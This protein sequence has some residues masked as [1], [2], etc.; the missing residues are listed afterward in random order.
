MGTT[1]LIVGLGNPGSKYQKTRHNIGY[2]VVDRLAR[3]FKMKSSETEDDYEFAVT[4]YTDDTIVLMRPL[5]F[6][7]RS[8]FAVREFF[9][10]YEVS[11][12]NMLIV[13]DDVNLDFGTLRMRPSGS[14]G[15]QKG[16]QSIIFE[17]RTDE[18]PRL[19]IGI[20]NLP[21]MEIFKRV[22]KQV[23]EEGNEVEVET[24]ELA[25]YVLSNFTDEEMKNMDR[26]LDCAKDA[27]LS[28]VEHGIKE[29]MNQFNKNVLE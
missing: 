17:M 22:E 28:F 9:E 5:T 6:M 8:G 27:V 15:G 10:N 11:G 1:K 20:R 29:T 12:E 14:D 19:R 2:L 4:E 13:Y 7:N 25:G 24:Y 3:F 23:N 16:M 21:E 26:V 18:I